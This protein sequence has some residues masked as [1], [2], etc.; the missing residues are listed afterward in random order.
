MPGNDGTLHF[1]ELSIHRAVWQVIE[2]GAATALGETIARAFT[3]ALQERVEVRLSRDRLAAMAMQGLAGQLMAEGWQVSD[4]AKDAYAIA[5]AMLAE[6][7]R[8]RGA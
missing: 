5:D 7:E 6:R 3:E 2:G 8:T 1:D 4:V